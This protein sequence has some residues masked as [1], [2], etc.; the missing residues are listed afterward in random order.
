[1]LQRTIVLI[2]G[3][4]TSIAIFSAILPVIGQHPADSYKDPLITINNLASAAKSGSRPEAEALLEE[5]FKQFGVHTTSNIPIG[6]LKEQI[7]AAQLEYQPGLNKGIPEVEI[8]HFF[9]KIANSL[10]LPSLNVTTE[11]IRN[12]RCALMPMLPHLVGQEFEPDTLKHSGT[13]INPRLSPIEAAYVTLLLIEQKRYGDSITV[14]SGD[15]FK[16]MQL[17]DSEPEDSFT[18]EKPSAQ[19]EIHLSSKEAKHL[20][21][22]IKNKTAAEPHLIFEITNEALN[23]LETGR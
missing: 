12:M 8:V 19:L 1:M 17:T 18:A 22:V 2:T 15:E 20:D 11:E 3:A 21:E 10:S 23:L 7:L 13:S 16:A 9:R 6:M 14:A 4:F 5:I